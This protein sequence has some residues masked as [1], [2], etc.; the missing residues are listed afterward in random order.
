MTDAIRDMCQAEI[1]QKEALWQFSVTEEMYLS[2]I[3]KKTASLLAACCGAGA[4]AG[5]LAPEAVDR[6]T[7]FG[8]YLG[9]C[10]QIT[11]DLLDFT[12]DSAALGKP[13]GSDLAQGILTLPVIYL[14]HNAAFEQGERDRRW[15]QQPGFTAGT[16][17]TPGDRQG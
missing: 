17:P 14:L 3:E 16:D 15:R 9:L 8:R 12:G 1:E 4:L 6:L 5:G 13:A 2:R 11:D 7:A 10:F